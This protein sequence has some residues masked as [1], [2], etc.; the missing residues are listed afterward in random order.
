[1]ATDL[2]TPKQRAAELFARDYARAIFR[3][4]V[5]PSG[6][7]P[8][9]LQVTQESLA[10]IVGAAFEIGVQWREEAVQAFPAANDASGVQGTDGGK[11][12]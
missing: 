7:A 3:E 6:D 9:Y 11:Q 1:M 5:R 2:P 10:A 12:P 8:S 4:K